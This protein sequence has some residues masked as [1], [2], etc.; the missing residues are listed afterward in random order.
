MRWILNNYLFLTF[1]VFAGCTGLKRLPPNEKLYTGA[2]IQ[3]VYSGKIKNKKE[4]TSKIKSAIRPETNQ[5]FL[6]MR[7][8]LWLHQTAGEPKKDKGLR[9]KLREQGEPPVLKS[10]VKPAQTAKYIDAKLFNSGIFNATTEYKIIEYKRTVKIKYISRIHIPYKIKSVTTDISQPAIDSLIK[11]ASKK[12]LL[13]PGNNYDLDLL[14]QERER[15]DATL[16][17]N[18]FYYFNP[19]Y[20]LFKADTQTVNKLVSFTLTLKEEIPQKALEIYKIGKVYINPDY[21]LQHNLHSDSLNSKPLLVD[22]VIFTSD[23]THIKPWAILQNVSLRPH[24]QYSRKKHNSTLNRLMTMGTYKFV[25][26]KFTD[27]DTVKTKTLN[28]RLF[29]TPMQK[30]TLR[31]EI[32]MVSK[33]NDFLG[34]QLNINYQ[35]RNTFQGAELLNVNGGGSFE[36]QVSG[37]YKNLY[38][39]SLNSK[40]ELIFPRYIVPFKLINPNNFFVPKTKFSLGYNYLK[41]IAYFDLRSFQFTYG[42]KWKESTCKEHELNPVSV[43]IITVVNKTPEFNSLLES[44]PF[45]KKSYNEQFIAG[46]QYSFLYNEQLLSGKKNQL[47]FNLSTETSGNL[48]SL[49]NQLSGRPPNEAN[50]LRIANMVYSQFGKISADLRNY[51]NFKHSK[52]VTRLFGG[53]GKAYGNSSTLPYIKQFFS[54]GAN[55]IRAFPI[56]S[57]GPGTYSSEPQSATLFLQQG[58]DI[59]LEGNFEYRFDILKSLK[60]ALFTDAGNIWLFKSNP[61]VMSAP[62]ALN[63]FYNEIAVGAGFGLR[64]D[65]T[66]FVLRFD[67]ATPLR[68]PSLPKGQRWLIERPAPADPSW[69]S[70]NLILNIAIGY[71][72]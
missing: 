44:N 2:I 4:I 55:S 10:S 25:R 24:N 8:K 38:S 41:R 72:F 33:S 6:G 71:P 35:N 57:L 69:R 49:V 5:S 45:I 65:V 52:I 17:D 16:K 39:Y 12:T 37:K 62:F 19:D 59:K 9:K 26:I 53:V 36:T 30:R 3:L 23:Q 28:M 1:I 67:L 54:G 29:L 32:N 61:A 50:P 43:N 40:V 21:S 64:L 42:F 56:N 22:S 66:F 7:P 48:I 51:L 13:I 60:G 14:K 18:G 27:D 20:F 46:L 15:L 63:E 70:D 34:P 11:A 31:N 68:K 58:G 47:Y